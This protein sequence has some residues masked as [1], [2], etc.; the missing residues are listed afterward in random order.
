MTM[1]KKE[2]DGIFLSSLTKS[3]Q[4]SLTNAFPLQ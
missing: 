3:K 1:M 2:N 4:T